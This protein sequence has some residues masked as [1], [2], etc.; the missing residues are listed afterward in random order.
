[1][2]NTHPL[3]HFPLDPVVAKPFYRLTILASTVFKTVVETVL[4]GTVCQG[5]PERG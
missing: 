1:M 5:Q 2:P 3:R 4:C